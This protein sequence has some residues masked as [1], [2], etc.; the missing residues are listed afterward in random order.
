MSIIQDD[1]DDDDDVDNQ[2][3]LPPFTFDSYISKT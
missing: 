3:L 1:D 2:N